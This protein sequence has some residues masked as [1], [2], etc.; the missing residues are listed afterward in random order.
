MS[1]Q[2]ATG[3]AS[4]SSSAASV[5]ASAAARAP[6]G[7]ARN[8]RAGMCRPNTVSVCAPDAASSGP[9]IDGSVSEWQY[10][11]HGAAAGIWPAA[12]CRY[13][14]S[15]PAYPSCTWNVPANAACGVTSGSRSRGSRR[16]TRL[17]FSWAPSGAEPF[18]VAW[19]ATV[20]SPVSR[21]SAAGARLARM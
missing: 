3:S 15:R 4:T 10:A 9:R 14:S 21:A 5:A 20:R 7:S 6:S 13:A 19:L 12:A 11:S 8:S 2:S 17:T 1:R 18:D 16:S